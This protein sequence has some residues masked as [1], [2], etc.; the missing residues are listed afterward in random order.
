MA[1][2]KNMLF[3]G[4]LAEEVTE[5]ILHAAFIPF[6][7]LRSVQI[8]RDYSKNKARGFGFVEFDLDEDCADALENM[9]GA[10]LFGQTLHCSIAKPMKGAGEKGKAVWSAESWIAQNLVD[11]K[12]PDDDDDDEAEAGGGVQALPSLQPVGGKTTT[13]TS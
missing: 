4:G 10:E 3:V 9:E 12:A 6:G 13:S 7:D 5:E 2:K 1:A 8:P 11:G